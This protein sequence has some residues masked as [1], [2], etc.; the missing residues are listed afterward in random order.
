MHRTDNCMLIIF[1]ASGDLTRRKL[2]P[3]LF[4]LYQK[5]LLPEKF[6]V[7]GVGRTKLTDTTFRKNLSKAL[8]EKT[9][10]KDTIKKF[11]KCLHYQTTDIARYLDVLRL[12]TESTRHAATAGWNR[13]D[14]KFRH[15]VQNIVDSR[16]HAERFLMAMP[17]HQD[18]PKWKRIEIK[19]ESA[20]S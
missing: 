15:P 20:A 5:N 4:S 10:D 18:A 2:V 1:G 6:G 9:K 3:A 7:L 19:L 13:R 8:E 12:I 14:I 17:V 16:H 11:I